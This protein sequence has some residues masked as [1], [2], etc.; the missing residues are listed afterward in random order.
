MWG[1]DPETARRLHRE[2]NDATRAAWQPHLDTLAVAA[3]DLVLPDAPDGVGMRA[4][5]PAGPRPDRTLA[6]IHGGGWVLGSIETADA[7]CRTMADLTGWEVVSIDYRC[8]PDHPFPAA[9]DDVLAAVRWL[10]AERSW[11]AVG[12]DSAG[13]TLSAVVA[14][15]IG[16][17]LRGQLLVYPATDPHLRS[18]SAQEFVDGPFLTR[19]DMEWFYAQY[20][21]EGAVEDPRANLTLPAH[22]HAAG[23]RPVPAVVLTVGHDPLRD[24][25]IA[26]ASSLR[27]AGA[28]VTWIHAPEL[29]HV[30]F[31]QAGVLPSAMRRVTQVCDAARSL[32]T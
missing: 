8:A 4:Y 2:G 27:D 29:F 25:G 16:P 14:R 18:A 21:P 17:G 23:P 6:W 30:A 7:I 3:E 5:R 20:L 24:E 1:L 9:V 32:F 19:R 12:G 10:L 13:A 26:Y 22:D 11:V 28:P 15:E 31:T